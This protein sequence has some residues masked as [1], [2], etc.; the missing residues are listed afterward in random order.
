[1]DISARRPVGDREAI[2]SNKFV[3]VQ[4][5]IHPFEALIDYRSLRLAPSRSDIF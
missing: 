2:T 1:M 5:A 3:S 4:L